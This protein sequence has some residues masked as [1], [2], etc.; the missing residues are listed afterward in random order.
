MMMSCEH[1]DMLKMANLLLKLTSSA[2]LRG[3]VSP[4][5]LQVFSIYDFI[6]KACQKTD[7]GAYARKTFSNLIKEG[8]EFKDEVTTLCHSSRFPGGRGAQTPTTTVLGLTKLLNILG[9]K[10]AKAFKLEAFGILERYLDGDMS[11]CTE[12]GENKAMGSTKS[13][14][15]FVGKVMQRVEDMTASEAETMPAVSYVYATRSTAFPGLVKI[16]RSINLQARLSSLNTACAPAPHR[17]VA[18]APTLDN[19]RD[20][21][22]AHQFFADRRR[23]GEFFEVE[24]NEIKAY[25]THHITTQFNMDMA[26]RLEQ[27]QGSTFDV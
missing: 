23:Q 22:T 5:G 25:F 13:Y 14:Q 6:T 3:M 16:G 4:D 19:I 12:I 17:V 18:V 26:E 27:M 7:T 8:S 21:R 2:S 10:V 15:K 11:L 1:T 9:G 24:E 20:E